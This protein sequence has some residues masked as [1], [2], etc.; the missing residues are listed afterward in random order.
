MAALVPAFG[1]WA[2]RGAAVIVATAGGADV[3]EEASRLSISGEAPSI[4]ARM[5]CHS[6]WKP[7]PFGSSGSSTRA[8]AFHSG[9][10]VVVLIQSTDV[11][12]T[13]QRP[14]RVACQLA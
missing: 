4:W 11:L 2:P 7:S 8:F 9:H 10:G 6:C 13:Q 14:L 5:A 1:A 12:L 3:M